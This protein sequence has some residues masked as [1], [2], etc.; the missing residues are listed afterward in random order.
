MGFE[1]VGDFLLFRFCVFLFPFYQVREAT[2]GF[3]VLASMRGRAC[4]CMYVRAYACVCGG[5]QHLLPMP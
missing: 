3:W 1:L 4:M 5:R 2:L